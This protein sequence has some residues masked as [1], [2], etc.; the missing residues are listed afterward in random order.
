MQTIWKRAA[1]FTAF[2]VAVAVTAVS[3]TNTDT[4]TSPPSAG[5]AGDVDAETKVSDLRQKY[6]WTG[7]YHTRALEHSYRHLMK[8]KA[9]SLSAAAKCR[10]ADEALKDFTRAYRRNGS[11]L[12]VTEVSLAGT[13]CDPSV[14]KQIIDGLG[15]SASRR[16]NDLSA[17]A[18]SLLAQVEATAESVASVAAIR[19]AIHDI[20][21]TAAAS[22]PEA[23]AGAVI[24]AG[25]L[26]ISSVEYWNLY[27]PA[28]EEGI[29]G[30]APTTYSREVGNESVAKTVFKPG[31][32]SR[33]DGESRTRRIIKADVTAFLVTIVTSWWAGPI[34][35]DAAAIR[36]AASSL[37]AGLF[38]Y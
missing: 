22:L 5:A 24:A 3:C 21:N 12:G 28:W 20:Q 29:S 36:G 30:D 32:I 23:E 9:G 1:C 7:D 10:L 6:G 11:P 4:A 18:T 15:A 38:P 34:A 19:A 8:H 17:T 16:M 25:E 26:A 14:K 27:A 2:T 13:A 31:T 35:W 33:S 37:I